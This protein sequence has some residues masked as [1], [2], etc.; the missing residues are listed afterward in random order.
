MIV[1][2]ELANPKVA[3]MVMAAVESGRKVLA[4][5]TGTPP[6]T[7]SHSSFRS[8]HRTKK[9]EYSPAWPPRSRA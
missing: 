5:M 8:F 1:V 3:H 7:Q 9:R 6:R 4:A 2:G